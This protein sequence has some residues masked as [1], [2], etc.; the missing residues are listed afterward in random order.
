VVVVGHPGYYPRFGF[1]RASEQGIVCE[2]DLPDDVFML[3]VLDRD[4]VRGL[5]GLAKY[6]TEF[7]SV[8]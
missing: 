7:S 5:K 6:R 2:W 3:R 8:A 1:R 4:A